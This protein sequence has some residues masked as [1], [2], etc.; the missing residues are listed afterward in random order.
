MMLKLG[1]LD[2]GLLQ[3]APTSTPLNVDEPVSL[4][5]FRE[6]GLANANREYGRRR[7]TDR[8]LV[9]R[10]HFSRIKKNFETK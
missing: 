6:G 5:L 7:P 10:Q 9:V 8:Q 2:N 1:K 3:L 4:P